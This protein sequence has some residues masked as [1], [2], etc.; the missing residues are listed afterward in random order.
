MEILPPAEDM[1][2]A[3]LLLIA[4]TY[5]VILLGVGGASALILHA[6]RCWREVRLEMALEEA[7]RDR[8][9]ARGEADHLR[10]LLVR[11]APH[12]LPEEPAA[13]TTRIGRHR[14]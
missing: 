11:A 6:V 5:A 3:D 8:D 14:V 7:C 1:I 4:S 12:L 2:P 13:A 10:G 9:A